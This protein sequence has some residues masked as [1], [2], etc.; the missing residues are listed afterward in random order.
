M[1]KIKKGDTVVVRT[2]K[3]KGKEGTVAQV[4]KDNKVLVKGINQVKKTS[5]RKPKCR[6]SG[7]GS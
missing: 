3:D 6:Y 4:F 1:Q 2:G 7:R 5:K